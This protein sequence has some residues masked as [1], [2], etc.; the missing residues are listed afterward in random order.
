MNI[1]TD[2]HSVTA[3]F[4]ILAAALAGCTPTPLER[5]DAFFERRD[6]PRALA[7]YRLAI[8]QDGWDVDDT[9]RSARYAAAR[10]AVLES[11]VRAFENA[12]ATPD[13]ADALREDLAKA[14]HDVRIADRTPFTALGI[15]VEDRSR[16]ALISW[17]ETVLNTPA[18]YAARVATLDRALRAGADADRVARLAAIRP[19][20]SAMAAVAA[21]DLELARLRFYTALE[22][23]GANFADRGELKLAEDRISQALA[24]MRDA[25]L[26]ED[27]ADVVTALDRMETALKI[28]PKIAGG[29]AYRDKL[30]VKNARVAELRRQ[31][32]AAVAD[33]D[34][35]S[36]RRALSELFAMKAD[37]KT[38]R[39]LDVAWR[40]EIARVSDSGHVEEA[41][42]A[43]ALARRQLAAV[44][45]PG[46][47]LPESAKAFYADLQNR[48]DLLA[49]GRLIATGDA[50][51]IAGLGGVVFTHTL[52]VS[53][54]DFRVN[55]AYAVDAKVEVVSRRNMSK[56]VVDTFLVGNPAYDGARNAVDAA[57]RSLASAKDTVRA[58]ARELNAAL[59]RNRDAAKNN[60]PAESTSGGEYS[61]SAAKRSVSDAE[62][63]LSAAQNTLSS[64]PSQVEQQRIR[65]VPYVEGV[66]R[67]TGSATLTLTHDGDAPRVFTAEYS[68]DDSFIENPSPSDGVPVD[69]IDLS[70][71]AIRRTL[72]SGAVSK[73]VPALRTKLIE[74]AIVVHTAAEKTTTGRA[75]LAAKIRR[76]A[77]SGSTG[78]LEPLMLSEPWNK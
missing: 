18:G 72:M 56:T 61:L 40:G 30:V 77:V 11:A 69:E 17:A 70:E 36:A 57:E 21:G 8:A 68:R 14:K 19:D 33:G 15:R 78:E 16:G 53:P 32:D 58:R 24:A 4:L 75:A 44:N 65:V 42:L 76:L 6:F 64:T 59:D 48:F 67:G 27:T 37:A 1:P 62:Y 38:Y 2:R 39:E 74:H 41:W 47:A 31:A 55:V 5:G 66:A 71:A 50:A 51:A 12:P 43:T 34:P 3:G 35:T 10:L 25:H 23:D 28:W 29:V 13:D 52:P 22:K 20:A 45:I 46:V 7:Q 54:L 49:N 26:A 9:G 60:R 63:A 73:A